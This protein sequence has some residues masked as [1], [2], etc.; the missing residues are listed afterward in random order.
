MP[1]IIEVESSRQFS[2]EMPREPVLD[3]GSLGT[4]LELKQRK[5][6]DLTYAEAVKILEYPQFEGDRPLN[7]KHVIFLTRQMKAGMFRWEQVQI[8]VCRYDGK[9]YRMNGQHTCWARLNMPEKNYPAPAQLLRYEAASE[10]DM[11][12]LYASIDRNKARSSGNVVVSYLAGRQEFIQFNKRILRALA[13]ALAF[14]KW[15]LESQRLLHTPDDRAYLMLTD[16]YQLTTKVGNFINSS[17]SADIKHLHRRPVI[18]AMYATFDKA[19]EIAAQFWK[20]VALGEMLAKD[21]PRMQLRNK[22]LSSTIAAGGRA[23]TS[24][25]TTTSSEEMFRWCILAWNAHRQGKPLKLFK[26]Y[27]DTPRQTVR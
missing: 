20:A 7:D 22:L 9:D 16:H 27:L 3:I 8:I 5:A 12:Q 19:P 15:D 13:E 10:H 26:V 4:G 2:T 25:V 18:A 23:V 14:W 6:L 17:K 21:D 11:R 24:D 1:E